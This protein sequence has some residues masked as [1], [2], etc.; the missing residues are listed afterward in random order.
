MT[1]V[2]YAES[3]LKRAGLFDKDSDYNGMLG[4]AALE[5]IKV[6]SMQGHSGFSA[7]IV[8]Q[9]VEKLLRYEPLTPLTY[10][11]DEWT[12]VSEMSGSP[13]WQNN[14]KPT[15]FSRDGGKTH[16]DLDNPATNCGI[17]LSDDYTGTTTDGD[18]T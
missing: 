13:M 11:P 4:E 15:T 14:R 17:P 6:F 7:S 12:D 18:K 16:Y 10:E 9:L 5:I 3:E 8:T 2:D 1:L